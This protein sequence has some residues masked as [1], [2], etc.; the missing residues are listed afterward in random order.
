MS[1]SWGLSQE[2]YEGIVARMAVEV[3]QLRV[4]QS[5]TRLPM[6]RTLADIVDYCKQHEQN[7]PLIVPT[8]ENPFREKKSCA[9]GCV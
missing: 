6:K 5:A 8:K 3:E 1:S 4:Y 7:D 9:F 2:A